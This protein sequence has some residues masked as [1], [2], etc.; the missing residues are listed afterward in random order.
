MRGNFFFLR[1][2]LKPVLYAFIYCVLFLVALVFAIQYE[3]DGI[4]ISET[5]NKYFY[6][7]TVYDNHIDAPYLREL[8]DEL[9]KRIADSKYTSFSE[10]RKLVSAR[11]DQIS[12]VIEFFITDET[13]DMYGI[14]E[15]H[16]YPV[17]Y[18]PQLGIEYATLISQKNWAGVYNTQYE[19]SVTMW[20]DPENDPNPGKPLF[21]D[22]DRVLLTGRFGFDD[23]HYSMKATSLELNNPT[24]ARHKNVLDNNPVI[25][26]PDDKECSR[27]ETDALIEKELTER[28]MWDYVQRIRDCKK[29]FSAI[30]VSDQSLLMSFADNSCY[31]SD[32]RA[33]TSDDRG[34]KLCVIHQVVANKDMLKVGDHIKLALSDTSFKSQAVAHDALWSTGFPT[35]NAEFPEYGDYE[36]YEIVGIFNF[37][38][39]RN[40]EE[41]FLKFNMN[42]VFIPTDKTAIEDYSGII[43]LDFSFKILGP[44]YDDFMNEFEEE[45]YNEKYVLRIVDT[46]WEDVEANYESLTSRR[47]VS[48]ISAILS[49]GVATV[50]CLIL[51]IKHFRYEFGLRRLMGASLWNASGAYFTGYAVLC[52]PAL[53]ASVLATCLIYNKWLMARMAEVIESG[54]PDTIGCFVLLAP[55]IGYAFLAGLVLL[56]FIT[57]FNKEKNLLG[58]LK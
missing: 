30:P 10:N 33:L 51:I 47:L 50:I 24:F 49:M 31:I 27:S 55:W 11:S 20:R 32:G 3:L 40:I 36:D 37:Y 41:D 8:P 13:L 15:G 39:R 22:G 21:H 16:I 58:M 57:L 4:A 2:P 35:I 53:L 9:V 29:T 38:G 5:V 18:D 46:G 56:F 54:L 42:T 28:G 19:T 45:L 17:S 25:F 14:M 1:K 26:L 44:D 12:S 23:V 52:I 43:P 7:G 6:V 48:L 34:K